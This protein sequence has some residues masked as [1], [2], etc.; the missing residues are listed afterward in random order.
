MTQDDFFVIAILK[1]CTDPELSKRFHEV[2]T[3]ELT[4]EKLRDVAETYERAT[5]S[6]N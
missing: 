5:A 6:N 1:M 4:W 3:N 2:K